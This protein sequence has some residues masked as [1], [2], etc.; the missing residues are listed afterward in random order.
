MFHSD[1]Q[2]IKQDFGQMTQETGINE[3]SRHLNEF[4]IK[5]QIGKRKEK[6]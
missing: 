5:I 6:T 3:S 1:K 2:D 4:L